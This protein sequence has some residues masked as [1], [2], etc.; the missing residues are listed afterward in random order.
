MKI[1]FQKN[2]VKDAL[3]Q[4]FLNVADKSPVLEDLLSQFEIAVHESNN[5]NFEIELTDEK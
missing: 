4:Y 5:G 2:E 3:I 1:I